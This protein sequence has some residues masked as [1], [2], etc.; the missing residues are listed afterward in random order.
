MLHENITR[1]DKFTKISFEAECLYNRLLTQ[2][3]DY[4][5]V[6]GSEGYLKD[7]C[8][9]KDKIKEIKYLD[10]IKW[11]D[12]LVKIGLLKSYKV[13]DILYLHFDRFYDFQELRM[14]RLRKTSIP[15]YDLLLAIDG[16]LTGNCLPEL[17]VELEVKEEVEVKYSCEFESVFFLYPSHRRTCKKECYKYFKQIPQDKVS[18]F[19]NN[20]KS[21]I[22]DNEKENYK[23]VKQSARYFKDWET[24][25]DT[26]IE[27]KPTTLTELRALV[28]ADK[29]ENWTKDD[30]RS[31]ND[32]NNADI[33]SSR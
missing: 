9:P 17:E 20:L 26:V 10:I 28:K 11:R 16:Q 8:F 29:T 19:T 6:L 1:S 27:S 5:N 23:Y 22:K 13:D 33:R 24:V 3:D 4:G 12:E 32:M 7:K 18:I 14:N 31:Y 21:Y 2:T 25:I 30:W 15:S